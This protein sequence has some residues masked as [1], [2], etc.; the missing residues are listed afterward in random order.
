MKS[1]FN[2]KIFLK[3]VK[4]CLLTNLKNDRGNILRVYV[5]NYFIGTKWP[6]G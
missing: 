4:A 5:E 2:F 6:F 1:Y 3:R